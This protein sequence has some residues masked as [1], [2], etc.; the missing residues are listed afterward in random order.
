MPQWVDKWIDRR[1]GKLGYVKAA[2]KPARSIQTLFSGE[3]PA[4]TSITNWDNWTDEQVEQLAVT[5]GWIYADIRLIA[6]TLSSIPFN[7]FEKSGEGLREVI[8][9]PFEVLFEFPNEHIDQSFLIEYSA[10]WFLLRG[11][12]YWWLVPDRSGQLAEIW[13]VPASRMEPVPDPQ[14]YIQGYAYSSKQGGKKVIIPPEQVLFVRTPN[15]FDYHRGLSPISAYRLDLEGDTS[16]AKWNRETFEQEIALRMLINL[17]QDTSDPVYQV[18]K[19]ELIDELQ[20]MGRRFW[21]GRAGDVDVKEFGLNPKDMEYLALRKLTREIVDSVHGIPGGFWSEMASRANADAARTIFIENAIWPM[22]IK[23]HSAITTQILRRY[24]G[25]QYRGRFA[26]ARPKDRRLLVLERRQYWMVKT[27][28]QAREDLGDP[29]LPPDDPRG[30]MLV[31]EVTMQRGVPIT[32]VQT[33]SPANEGWGEGERAIALGERAIALFPPMVQNLVNKEALEDLRRWKSIEL[34]RFKAG[35]KPSSYAFETEVIPD[36]VV[37]YI[38]NGLAQAESEQA[39][40]KLFENARARLLAHRAISAN[41]EIKQVDIGDI[42]GEGRYEVEEQLAR[43]L[44]AILATWLA[45]VARNI[46]AGDE[47]PLDEEAFANELM[48]VLV[49]FL[50][51]YASAQ[52]MAMLEE[53]GLDI[54][55]A[56]INAEVLAWATT[57]S[58]QLAQQLVQTTNKAVE[59]AV[60]QFRLNPTLTEEQI[61]S[62]LEFTFSEVRADLISITELTRALAIGVW[63]AQQLLEQLGLKLTRVWETAKDELVCAEICAPLDEQPEEVWKAEFPEG[64]PAHGNCRCGLRLERVEA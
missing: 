12:A 30:N 11:E 28:N 57:Y 3:S 52:V 36:Q 25:A 53:F 31:P 47:H 44:A 27:V 14:K 54:D 55:P 18:L 2:E 4:Y 20:N 51:A 62:L 15:P 61:A 58:S 13:P 32:T 48:A 37:S 19:Q 26:D 50:V 49:P 60:E 56:E 7:V 10:W 42:D 59:K 8:N 34:R 21:I 16:A 45:V 64:P 29:P 17:P 38:T 23:F 39:I 5:C 35:E 1:V 24:Y 46:A 33:A 41:V 22:A 6:A 40:K 9:H 43:E 63:L